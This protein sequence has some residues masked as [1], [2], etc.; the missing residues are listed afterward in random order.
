M[1]YSITRRQSTKTTT[2]I[3]NASKYTLFCWHYSF[4]CLHRTANDVTSNK[5]RRLLGLTRFISY[6]P[7][8]RCGIIST[9]II[10]VRDNIRRLK[11]KQKLESKE[12][13]WWLQGIRNPDTEENATGVLICL[14][15]LKA[16]GWFI[17]SGDLR[18]RPLEDPE[19]NQERIF[20][21]ILQTWSTKSRK[22]ME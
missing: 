7:K 14:V 20:L 8:H 6:Y 5:N 16:L 18:R 17:T 13:K 10:K 15:F 2:P 4:V 19:C 22:S 1:R 3:S 9:T 11:Q 12:G 21:R